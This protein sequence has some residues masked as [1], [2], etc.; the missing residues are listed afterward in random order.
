MRR[1]STA[2]TPST[3]VQE[4]RSAI[5]PEGFGGGIASSRGGDPPAPAGMMMTI[6]MTGEDAGGAATAGGG[7]GYVIVAICPQV[8]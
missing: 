6:V 2:P 1:I 8:V 3:T 4:L 7:V 5:T